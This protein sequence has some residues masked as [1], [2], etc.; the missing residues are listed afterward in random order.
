MMTLLKATTGLFN[1]CPRLCQYKTFTGVISVPT[2]Y[3]ITNSNSNTSHH[4]TFATTPNVKY[5]KIGDS[6]STSKLVTKKDVL[7]FA[8]LTLDTNPLHIDEEYAK[9]TQFKQPIVHGM[10]SLRYVC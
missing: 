7:E 9:G 2:Y 6:A 3:T 1:I 4:A 10:F 5:L 8:E